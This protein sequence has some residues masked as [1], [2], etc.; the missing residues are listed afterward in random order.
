MSAIRDE[1]SA[2]GVEGY[3]T[4]SGA[5][6]ENPHFPQIRA[7][8]LQNESRI[9]YNKVLDFCCG[10][11]EVSQVVQELGYALPQAS[12]PYTQAAYYKNFQQEC[13]NFTFEDII[14]G[15]LT[16][17]F[18][19]IICS[20]A[21]HLCPEKQLYPLVYQLFQHTENLIIITPHKRPELEKL[22]N[23]NLIFTDYTLTERGKKVFLKSYQFLY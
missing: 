4:Q 1:Y 7:L 5:Y 2:H 23:V 9:N 8:L 19:S 21:M 11:G 20:F 18:S 13:W 17:E 22:S 15:K 6:Y 14:K 12:D 10:S 3:Y 16:G